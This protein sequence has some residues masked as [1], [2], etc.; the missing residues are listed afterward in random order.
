[1][2]RRPPTSTP[3]RSWRRLVFYAI[4]LVIVGGLVA[5]YL[6]APDFY[7]RVILSEKNREHQAVE[8]ATFGCAISAAFLMGIAAWR[9]FRT[10]E[11]GGVRSGAV[12]V[13]IIGA[14]AFFFAGEEISWGQ[15]Y[16]GWST[17][18]AYRPYAVETNLHNTEMPIRL[19][20]LGSLFLATMFFVLPAAWRLD[21]S[22]KLPRGWQ[23]AIAE[24]PVVFCMAVAFTWREAKIVY[25]F[26]NSDWR[27]NRDAHEWYWG[28]LD[29]CGEHK[30]LLVA[31]ALL[32]YGIYR[33][34]RR[35]N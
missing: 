34:R 9:L 1:M 2:A 8:I 7:V 35:L 3:P 20:T 4:P 31:V 18:D 26:F 10:G 23:P 30:E 16:I 12:I 11:A 13:A 28:F 19:K 25:R 22:R 24:G 21:Q 17:P 27:E 33:V 15:S 29:Q 5:L 32:M 14:A 6:I